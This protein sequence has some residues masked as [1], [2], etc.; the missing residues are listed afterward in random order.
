MCRAKAP[1]EGGEGVTMRPRIPSACLLFY[2]PMKWN[3]R[4]RSLWESVRL[5]SC[6]FSANWFRFSF[7]IKD[8]VIGEIKNRI[9]KLHDSGMLC[10]KEARWTATLTEI[11]VMATLILKAIPQALSFTPVGATGN[12]WRPLFSLMLCVYPSSSFVPHS[13]FIKKEARDMTLSLIEALKLLRLSSGED[14]SRRCPPT[15]APTADLN[16]LREN[17]SATFGEKLKYMLWRWG[18]VSVRIC[19]EIPGHQWIYTR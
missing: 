6:W 16:Q 4:Q 15:G 19:F 8:A 12:L 14:F 10:R 2:L 11:K 7:P 17:S 3:Y 9:M 13:S 1:N 5:E 18:F